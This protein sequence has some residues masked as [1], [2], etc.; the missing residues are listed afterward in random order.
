MTTIE[1]SSNLSNFFPLVLTFLAKIFLLA[2]LI[3]TPIY[4]FYNRVIM[5]NPKSENKELAWSK[6]GWWDRIKYSRNYDKK[7]KKQEK[8]RQEY[9]KKRVNQENTSSENQDITK[10]TAKETDKI[11]VDINQLKEMTSKS[12]STAMKEHKLKRREILFIKDL[13][14]KNTKI[15]ENKKYS[16]DLHCI[17][18][19]I[20]HSDPSEATLNQI[21]KYIKRIEKVA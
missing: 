9:Q 15:R 10:T 7:L 4:Y 6:M 12:I 11:T 5:K 17:Y 3:C 1:I 13:L 16:N 19:L 21:I 2:A 20:K 18:S 8:L 14:K